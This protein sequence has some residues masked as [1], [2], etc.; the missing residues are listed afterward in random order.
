MHVRVALLH[1][2][3]RLYCVCVCVSAGLLK[4]GLGQLSQ[5]PAAMVL[6]SKDQLDAQKEKDKGARAVTNS[7]LKDKEN[8]PNVVENVAA[9]VQ[10]ES[11]RIQK[12]FYAVSHGVTA[13]YFAIGNS[14]LMMRAIGLL[15]VGGTRPKKF[16]GFCT[17]MLSA[18]RGWLL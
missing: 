4:L 7:V 17:G 13:D 15:V 5:L 18:T 14:R 11:W 10:A 9:K 3:Q 1:V 6:L 16:R 8:T 2:V 12:E